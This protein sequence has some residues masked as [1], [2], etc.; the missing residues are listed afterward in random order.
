MELFAVMSGDINPTH[1][2]DAFAE[3]DSFHKVGAHGM[4]SGVPHRAFSSL[5]E[6]GPG[7]DSCRA[8]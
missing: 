5:P 8:P 6:G 7:A 3:S 4:W 2:D 1:L